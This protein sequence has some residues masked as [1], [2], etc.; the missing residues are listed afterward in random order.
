MILN[1]LGTH[2]W[3]CIR[4]ITRSMIEDLA[5]CKTSVINLHDGLHDRFK[6]FHIHLNQLFGA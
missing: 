4:V 1:K 3:W 2:N 5:T 6:L